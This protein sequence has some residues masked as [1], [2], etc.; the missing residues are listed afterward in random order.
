MTVARLTLSLTLTL[1]GGIESPSLSL[2]RFGVEPRGNREDPR[3]AM[4][5]SGASDG[6]AV[7]AIIGF[8]S[9]SEAAIPK[10]TPLTISYGPHPMDALLVSYGFSLPNS[11]SQCNSHAFSNPD[12]HAPTR[13][14]TPL[15]RL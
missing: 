15:C 5:G 6:Q 2:I 8:R 12:I 1:I 4:E 10:G 9:T 3:L 14:L 13:P 11:R 7:E